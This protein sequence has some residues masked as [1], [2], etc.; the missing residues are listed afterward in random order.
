MCSNASNKQPP[1]SPSVLLRHCIFNIANITS[2]L[3]HTCN[4]YE[5]AHDTFPVKS[6]WDPCN[7]YARGRSIICRERNTERERAFLI[8][9]HRRFHRS[10]LARSACVRAQVVCGDVLVTVLLTC[11]APQSTKVTDGACFP[12]VYRRRFGVGSPVNGGA[13]ESHS[14]SVVSSSCH[15]LTLPKRDQAHTSQSATQ[16]LPPVNPE[17]GCIQPAVAPASLRFSS[18]RLV[19]MIYSDYFI[20]ECLNMRQTTMGPFAKHAFLLL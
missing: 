5:I 2:V 13:P 6:Y 17:T 20:T 8:P 4:A 1:V 3:S 10:K 14:C 7:R 19:L 18:S 16:P 9:E 12:Q 15:A 11:P